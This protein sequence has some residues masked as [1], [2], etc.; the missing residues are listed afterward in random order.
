MFFFLN[1]NHDISLMAQEHTEE[2]MCFFLMLFS[3][4]LLLF[5]KCYCELSS[6]YHISLKLLFKNGNEMQKRKTTKTEVH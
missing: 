3:V 4:L 5:G 6:L 2:E 1:G